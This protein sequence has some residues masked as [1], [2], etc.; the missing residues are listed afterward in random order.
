VAQN[1]HVS[2][3]QVGVSIVLGLHL[4]AAGKFVNLANTF[5]SEVLFS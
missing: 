1:F 4:R 5:Q 2:R 3:R